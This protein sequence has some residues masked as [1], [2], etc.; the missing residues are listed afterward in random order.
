MAR[1]AQFEILRAKLSSDFGIEWGTALFGAEAIASLPVLMRGKNIGRPKG[2]VIWRK[3]RV[4]GWSAELSQAFGVNQMADAWIGEGFA[5]T[6]DNALSGRW[7]GRVQQ[8]AASVS[9]GA[10]FDEGRE[11]HAR[12]IARIEAEWQAS[13]AEIL[14]EQAAE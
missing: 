10:F 12:E 2:W 8:L 1:H 4:K 14:A 3:A 13:L 11:R 9:A 7:L 5:S 6:R